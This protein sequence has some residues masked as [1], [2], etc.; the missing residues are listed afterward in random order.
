ME[1]AVVTSTSHQ[2]ELA[3]VVYA[4]VEL[5]CF[6]HSINKDVHLLVVEARHA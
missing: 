4:M 6:Q 2:A 3:E 5:L 1:S